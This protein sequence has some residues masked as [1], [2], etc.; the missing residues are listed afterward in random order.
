MPSSKNQHFDTSHNEAFRLLG[1][2]EP[3]QQWSAFDVSRDAARAGNATRFVTTIWNYHSTLDP[4]GRRTPTE[5]AIAKDIKTGTLWYRVSKPPVGAKR[6]T[7]VAHWNG[8][9]LA[10]EN[11]IPIIGVLKDVHSNRC[12]SSCIFDCGSPAMQRDGSAMWLQLVPR[13]QVSC[14]VR[15]IDI[16]QLTASGLTA[17]PLA[18]VNQRF[19]A[20]VLGALQ[21]TSEQRRT[22][23]ANASRFPRRIE[24]V[25]TVFDR[26]PD[27]VAEVLLR[28]TGSCEG[29]RKPAP[30]ARRSDGTPYLEV[31]HRTPL[32]QGGEDTVENAIAL[33]PNCHREAHYG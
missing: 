29:C 26:N 9:E 2:L 18:Q 17:E 1:A 11:Q 8:L 30:F 13:G 31:H 14:E 32:A 10:L 27:V 19:E 7:W 5:I 12:A 21:S 33:C 28:A 25:T 20:S 3:G 23:L 15:P 4:K 6:K 22:R 24:T 16:A